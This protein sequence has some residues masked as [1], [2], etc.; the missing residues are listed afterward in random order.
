MKTSKKIKAFVLSVLSF[1]LFVCLL[2][3]RAAN[4]EP[5]MK[6]FAKNA[7]PGAE[8]VFYED[9]IANNSLSKTLPS[10]ILPEKGS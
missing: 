7:Y 5:A 8:V 9:D 3:S 2:P 6:S 10:A 4:N 1:A